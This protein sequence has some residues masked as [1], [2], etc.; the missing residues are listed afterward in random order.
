MHSFCCTI[1]LF[2]NLIAVF[3]FVK[4]AKA[5]QCSDWSHAV[6]GGG[7]APLVRTPTPDTT[8]HTDG[9]GDVDGEDSGGDGDQVETP[10]FLGG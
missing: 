10:V 4:R 2:I 1:V 9:D 7:E 8:N 6:G 5:L 3:T